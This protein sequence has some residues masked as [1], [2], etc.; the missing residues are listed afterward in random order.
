M[1]NDR[2][3][4][5]SRLEKS[6]SNEKG[7]EKIEPRVEQYLRYLTYLPYLSEEGSPHSEL[8]QCPSLS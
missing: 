7:A 8:F 3:Q 6:C 1:S 4:K 2:K 5:R